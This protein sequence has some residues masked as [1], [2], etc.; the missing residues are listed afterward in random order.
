MFS[1]KSTFSRK[2]CSVGTYAFF[3]SPVLLLCLLFSIICLPCN[4]LLSPTTSCTE[5]R[6]CN[7]TTYSIKRTDTIFVVALYVTNSIKIHTVFLK[8]KNS[9][10]KVCSCCNKCLM[11]VWRKLRSNNSVS[12]CMP[13]NNENH[14]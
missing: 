5:V 3:Q 13:T 14:S 7:K 4:T 10:A 1:L 12:L 11:L 9:A 6:T 2:T 8:A